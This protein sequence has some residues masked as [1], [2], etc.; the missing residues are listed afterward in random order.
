MK[1]VDFEKVDIHDGFW[2]NRQNVNR[3]VSLKAIQKSYVETGRFDATKCAYKKWK[4]WLKPPHVFYDSDCAKFIE[5]WSYCLA[6]DRNEEIES[7]IDGVIDNIA[8]NQRADGYYN[9]HF[10]VSR[11]DKVFEYRSEHELYCLGHLIE[12]AVAYDKATGKSKLLEVCKRYV[13]YVEERFLVKKDTA[14]SCPGHPEI[15]LALIKLYEYT[16]AKKYL[17]LAKYFIY[18]RGTEEGDKGLNKAAQN[19][20]WCDGY[21]AQDFVPLREQRTAEGHS[22]RACYLYAGGADVARIEKDDELFH[23][24]KTIYE[25]IV[26]RRMY[27]TGGIGAKALTEAFDKDF[28]LPNDLAYTESCAAI[29]LIMFAWRLRLLDDD[30]RYSELIEKILYNGFLSGVSL[31]GDKFFYENPL[32]ID[33]EKRANS[34]E[35]FPISTRQ[36]D[37]SCSC[38]PPNIARLISQLGSLVYTYDEDSLTVEQFIASTACVTVGKNNVKINLGCDI[39]K[40]GTLNIEVQGL[41]GKTLRVRKPKWA[42]SF[43]ADKAWEARR[44]YL[45]FKVENDFQNFTLTFNASPKIIPADERV[46]TNRGT[47]YVVYKNVVYCAEAIDNGDIKEYAFKEH[48]KREIIVE[49]CSLYNA[50]SLRVPAF[51]S[52]EETYLK[53]I[54]YFAFANRG[55]SDMYVYIKHIK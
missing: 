54:P 31:D 52:G 24:L 22:V 11:K 50:N 13:D 48:D 28:I 38:C 47:A 34:K 15:E 51:K 44:G 16:G 53:M 37:F 9:A 6:K 23:A 1:Y 4:F 46:E 8:K 20:P 33:L 27:V 42:E 55:E 35:R 19:N 45:E 32:E 49:W 10:L 7:F 17:E 21:Y 2:S 29:A 26:E 36:K 39:N 25:N 12:A 14:F 43:T 40:N 41:N 5:A 18:V 3:E 30:A